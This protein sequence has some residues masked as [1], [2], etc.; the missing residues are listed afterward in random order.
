MIK[1]CWIHPL[2]NPPRIGLLTLL[3]IAGCATSTATSKTPAATNNAGP[4]INVLDADNFRQLWLDT[5]PLDKGDQVNRL[6]IKDDAVLAVT[7]GNVVY[8]VDKQTGVLKYFSYVD[9]GGRPIGAPIELPD[10][11][12]Y[13]AQS[14]LEVYKRHDGDLYR[15]V[16]IK[17]TISS[18]GVGEGNDVYIGV[19]RG[20]GEIVDV[21]ITE[22]Y[23]PVRW[24]LLTFGE[25]RG[26]PAYY[27]SVI[28]IGSA[29]GGVR[30]VN[31][32]RTA[33]WPLDHDAFFTGGQ[34]LGDI[35][36]DDAG[37]YAASLSGRLVCLDR[38]SGKLRWQ[39]FAPVGLNTGPIVTHTTI[40]QLVPDTGLA[41]I[42]KSDLMAVDPEG[43]RKIEQLNRTPRWVCPEAAQFVAEDRLFTYV[44]STTG[45]LLALDRDTGQIRYRSA[46]AFTAI[47]TNTA[48]A[49]I[50][51]ATADGT[52]YAIKPALEPGNP[53][54]LP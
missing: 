1:S 4:V 42:D 23:V 13:P 9:G 7:P 18:N 47:S 48:T 12:V 3:A 15:S 31:P 6:Y 40:Y 46:R 10:Y 26:S 32:D 45:Q 14:T 22:P 16:P 25:V 44:R 30:A 33:L 37:V 2:R 36:A 27:Q 20:G 19:D 51:A 43:R 54:Y 11:M 24:S 52:I 21:D 17:L 38:N 53:G 34:I 41:A 5:V 28:Y 8:T 29:D 35:A 49:T 39:Y 50:Y